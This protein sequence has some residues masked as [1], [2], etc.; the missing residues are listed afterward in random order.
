MMLLLRT[1]G[2]R[3]E[4]SQNQQHFEK[5]SLATCTTH[6][7]QKTSFH[8]WT[9]AITHEQ[10]HDASSKKPSVHLGF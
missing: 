8:T 9:A 2:I 5:M 3:L 6:V 1:A 10:T 7:I 4:T